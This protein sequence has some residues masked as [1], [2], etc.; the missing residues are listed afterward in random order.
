MEGVIVLAIVVALLAVLLI[1][2]RV[3]VICAQ[4][5][6]ARQIRDRGFCVKPQVSIAGFPFLTQ[7]AAGRLNKVVIRAAGKKLGPVKVRH[8]DLTLHGIRGSGGGR[9]ACQLSGTA[10]IG[11]AGLPGLAGLA[12]LPGLAGLAG[13]TGSAAR[14]ARAGSGAIRI[15]VICAGGIP[16]TL[17][18]SLRDITVPLPALPP[19]MRI[20]GVSVTGQGVL[21]RIAGQNVSFGS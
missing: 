7:V 16:V 6:L 4:D 1:A 10:L 12:G 20:E 11:F 2:D 5:R 18:G 8:L 17:P 19:G 15:G 14:V 13:M 9:T 3:A 21:V